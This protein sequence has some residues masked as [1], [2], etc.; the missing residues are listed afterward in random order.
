M[1][2][3]VRALLVLLGIMLSP[4]AQAACS[5]ATSTTTTFAAGSSYDVQAGTIPQVTAPTSLSCNGSLISLISSNSAKATATSTNNF[6][7]KDADGDTINYRLSADSAGSYTFTQGGTIDYMN[8]SL[9]S[10]LGI[11]NGSNFV[12]TMYAALTEKPNIPAGVYTDTVLISWN[13][14]ICHGIGALG[15]C[16]LS[17]TGTGTTLMTIKLTVGSDCRINAQALSFGSAPLAAQFNSVTQAVAVDCTKNSA[18]TVAFTSG[19]SGA[20]RPWRAMSDGA[21]HN[22]QY[23]I[24]RADGSTIWDLTNPIPS[25][26]KGAGGLTPSQMQVYVAKI[27]PDQA[28]PPAGH[29]TDTV[30]VVIGF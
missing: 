23:N 25:A 1:P 12:P 29:Y 7:L 8:S 6:K 3:I 10:L 13:Y 28:T 27:N 15:V 4:A 20:S 5:L 21:G 2:M 14:T 22:L 11:L 17:E 16:V 18:Y 26:T 24:Y 30:S 19:T 9:L